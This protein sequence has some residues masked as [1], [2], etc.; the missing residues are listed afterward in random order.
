MKAVHPLMD[1]PAQ[2]VADA[3]DRHDPQQGQGQFPRFP[4]EFHPERHTPVLDEVEE[5]PVTEERNGLVIVERQLD[6]DLQCLIG[7]QHEQDD[8]EGAL[9]RFSKAAWRCGAAGRAR[10]APSKA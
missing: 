10:I 8:E 5:A 1:H 9:H 6:P 2:G 4:A 3:D 7:Q